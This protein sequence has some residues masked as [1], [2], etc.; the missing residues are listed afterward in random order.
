MIW[1]DIIGD[2]TGDRIGCHFKTTFYLSKIILKMSLIGKQ[3]IHKNFQS[4]S[5]YFFWFPGAPIVAILVS[6]STWP[7]W[8]EISGFGTFPTDLLEEN[9]PF[10]KIRR[11]IRR[12]SDLET[13]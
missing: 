12:I 10:E 5:F 3:V 11:K 2:R 1:G 9:V 6:L 7:L 4:E 8:A 13:D